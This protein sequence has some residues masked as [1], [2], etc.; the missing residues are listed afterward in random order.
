MF[1]KERELTRNGSHIDKHAGR[2]RERERGGGGNLILRK[3]NR[4]THL[5]NLTKPS[6]NA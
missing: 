2:E 6:R 1:K 5:W 3:P 4:S